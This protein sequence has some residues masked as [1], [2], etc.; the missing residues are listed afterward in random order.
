[1]NS[2]IQFSQF[3]INYQ[4]MYNNIPVI[5]QEEFDQQARPIQRLTMAPPSLAAALVPKLEEKKWIQKGL[6]GKQVIE[7]ATKPSPKVTKVK[8]YWKG[9]SQVKAHDRKKKAGSIK[10]KKKHEEPKSFAFAKM[11][12]D[13]KESVQLAH[14]LHI[15]ELQNFMRKVK[16]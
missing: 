8:A 4:N 9:S 6:W 3:C 10:N 11:P 14:S 7:P 5:T 16:K 13:C 2:Q 12:E 1:M 15:Q